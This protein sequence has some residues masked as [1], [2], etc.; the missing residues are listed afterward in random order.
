[1]V[2]DADVLHVPLITVGTRVA[3][4][5]TLLPLSLICR[6]GWRLLFESK[7]PCRR[8]QCHDLG[9]RDLVCSAYLSSTSATPSRR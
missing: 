1:M 8:L 3:D 6:I 5:S 4:E 9:L 2:S 7:S